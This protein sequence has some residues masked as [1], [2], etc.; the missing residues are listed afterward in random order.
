MKLIEEIRQRLAILE[1]ISV[2]IQD[3]SHLHAGHAGSSGGGHFSLTIVS[4]QFS[5]KSRIMR[6]RAIYQ[7]LNDLIPSDIHAVSIRAYAPE[8]NTGPNTDRTLS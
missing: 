5:G 2:E 8:E 3:D 1:P 4:S 7:A 6:H